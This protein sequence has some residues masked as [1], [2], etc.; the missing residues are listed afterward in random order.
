MFFA[1]ADAAVGTAAAF[2][3]DLSTWRATEA[4]LARAHEQMRLA[5]AAARMYFWDWNIVT[6]EIA[7][8]DGLEEATGLAPGGFDGTIEAFTR[9]VHPA[10]LPAVEAALAQALAGDA[11]YDIEFRM[12]RPDGRERWVVAR[13]TV[14]RDGTGEPLRMVGID[15]DITD[16]KTAADSARTALAEL[17]GIYAAAPLGLSVLDAQCRWTRINAA[18][19][20]LNGYAPE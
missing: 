15:L 18:M 7:W 9:L 17:E 6:G 4:D 10:D 14:L 1:F 3:V 19:A 8:S 13:G 16:R 20:A 2:V 11:E 5:I 12:L